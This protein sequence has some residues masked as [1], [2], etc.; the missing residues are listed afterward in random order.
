M[1]TTLST[2]C[3]PIAV[4]T[5]IFLQELPIATGEL[6]SPGPEPEGI[7]L[8]KSQND[9]QPATVTP[10]RLPASSCTQY[11]GAFTYENPPT[12]D[13]SAEAA[14]AVL[15]SSSEQPSKV[16]LPFTSLP[17]S[18]AIAPA[19]GSDQVE[20]ITETSVADACSRR[21]TGA[22]ASAILGQAPGRIPS[23]AI[24]PEQQS[25]APV[26]TII[27]RNPALE[28]PS[29][30][31]PF[32]ESLFPHGAI[33][34]SSQQRPSPRLERAA[35]LSELPAG[36][37]QI[38]MVGPVT[39]ATPASDALAITEEKNPVV[40]SAPREDARKQQSAPGPLTGEPMAGRTS[41]TIAAGP[42]IQ[43]F[44]PPAMAHRA[45]PTRGTVPSDASQANQPVLDYP[46][47]AN[48][49]SD[50]TASAAAD[51]PNRGD[52][53]F[54][55][56]VRNAADPPTVDKKGEMSDPP[57][58]S[59][60][61]QSE[62]SDKQR[63]VESESGSVSPDLG[64]FPSPSLLVSPATPAG[65]PAIHTGD[66]P[67]APGSMNDPHTS[68]ASYR[69]P[70]AILFSSKALAGPVQ[71]ARIFEN[72][73]QAEMRI[74]L[75]TAAFGDVQ[76]RTVVHAGDVGVQ[77]GSEKGDLRSFLANDIPGI[78]H[79]LQQQDLRLAQ[80]SFQQN[81]FSN[82]GDPSQHQSQSRPFN[83]RHND[84]AA[85]T[86]NLPIPETDS[87]PE[88]RN[89]ARNGLNILV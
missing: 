4:I 59:K 7:S 78:T 68:Q 44:S 29:E 17:E 14:P 48:V 83:Y 66:P 50:P 24:S 60:G 33:S 5:P 70:A 31:T 62:D 64:I 16:Q 45:S 72:A 61:T 82:S 18:S 58:T 35:D 13:A 75:N 67:S 43:L 30:I 79:N 11:A 19:P 57:V 81:G 10:Q 49:P 41:S 54:S 39:S 34:T 40:S 21:E 73:G 32:S 85:R 20:N 77:I 26:D 63:G 56:I 15:E 86:P 87:L 52:T 27:S 84:A 38:T 51:D 47:L 22:P 46:N 65:H 28:T 1:P 55:S 25:T 89:T 42:L 2:V 76:V 74:G 69:V 9:S 53:A 23:Q 8:D 12:G 3:I 88:L 36:Q 6:L 71:L 80:V 37:I